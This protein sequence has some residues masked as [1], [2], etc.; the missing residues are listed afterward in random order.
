[1]QYDLHLI[2]WL[3]GKQRHVIR[4]VWSAELNNH[5][6]MLDACALLQGFMEELRLGRSPGA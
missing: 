5:I 6:D 2:D 1:M 4:G 3:S